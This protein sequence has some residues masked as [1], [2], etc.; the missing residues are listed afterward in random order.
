MDILSNVILP[1]AVLSAPFVIVFFVLKRK[2]SANTAYKF[3]AGLA[4]VAAFLLVWINLAVGII[5]EP[6]NPA[7]LMYAGV[8]AIGAIGAILARFEAAGMAKAMF[9]AAF[10]QASVAIYALLAG[11]LPFVGL[12]IMNLF[13]VALFS[14][15][16]L[17]FQKSAKNDSSVN[18]AVM[19]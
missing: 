4:L 16:T 15:S 3:A 18:A 17:L 2:K 9:A 11:L 5:G 10:A 19:G 7:N 14:A 1:L 13:F 12:I 6:E 8:L